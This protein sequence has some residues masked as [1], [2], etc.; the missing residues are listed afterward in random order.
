MVMYEKAA[1]WDDFFHCVKAFCPGG[2]LLITA[3]Y[4]NHTC[5][6]ANSPL[7][8]LHLQTYLPSQVGEGGTECDNVMLC[9][10]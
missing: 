2:Y 9:D 8:R 3:Y 6:F 7:P 10:G 4:F 5:N 1:A